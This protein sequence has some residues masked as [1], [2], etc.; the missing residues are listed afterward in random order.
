MAVGVS[1]QGFEEVV[2]DLSEASVRKHFDA[3]EDVPWEDPEYAVRL[4]DPR[5]ILPEVD[6]VGRTEWYRSLPQEQQVYVGRYRYAN[7]MKVGNQF[8]QLLVAGLMLHAFH[9]GSGRPEFR[10]S[11]HEATEECHHIQMFQEFARK[12]CPEV[13]GGPAWFNWIADFVPMF[14]SW[15]PFFF[16][17]MVLGGE[18]PIDYFQKSMLRSGV[19]DSMHPLLVRLVQIH[20]AEEARHIGFAHHYLEHQSAK[21]GRV[22]R[23]F[24]SLVTP[25]AFRIMIDIIMKPGRKARRAMGMPKSVVKEIWWDAPESEETLRNTFADVR[26]MAEHTGLMNPVS[27]RLW[28]LL[29]ID[30]RAAR[31]RSEPSR[32]A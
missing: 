23:A 1:E 31:F 17:V 5:W 3:F 6:P 28:R 11:M 22:R 25:I 12:V 8:E 19:A 13:A 26:S 24:L 21:L 20:V 14:G 10:Y 18:E 30:G 4:D 27:R 15:T 7:M 32:A 29:G 2:Q 9:M 16:F